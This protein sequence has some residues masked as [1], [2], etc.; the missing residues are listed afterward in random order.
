MK[1]I[2]T[3]L[4]LLLFTMAFSYKTVR[5]FAEIKVADTCYTCDM[6]CEKEKEDTTEKDEVKDI[7][8][9]FVLG[10]RNPLLI[11]EI[12]T[13]TELVVNFTSANYS[14][15]VYCPPELCC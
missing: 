2:F 11:E 1:T 9:H 10:N 6:D 14:N 13:P 3:Y 12:I 8:F 7:L 4:L 5:Y 15:L